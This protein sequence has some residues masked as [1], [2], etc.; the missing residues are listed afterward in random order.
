MGNLFWVDCVRL[1]G[2]ASANSKALVNIKGHSLVVE[3]IALHSAR[4]W[5]GP[6]P[7][8]W[9]PPAITS[10]GDFQVDLYPCIGISVH[11]NRIEAP[12][13]AWKQKIQLLS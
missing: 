5:A 2:K 6:F 4:A 1:P 10:S 9:P 8:P 3:A 13:A 7:Q 12:S 11:F